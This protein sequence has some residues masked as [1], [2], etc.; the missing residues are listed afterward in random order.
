MGGCFSVMHWLMSTCTPGGVCQ[1]IIVPGS[2]NLHRNLNSSSSNSYHQEWH[3]LSVLLRPH[4]CVG[5]QHSLLIRQIHVQCDNLGEV[6]CRPSDPG[7]CA[8]LVGTRGVQMCFAC[9]KS[10]TATY[11]HDS[12]F[13]N[14]MYCFVQEWNPVIVLSLKLPS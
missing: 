8:V 5:R 13:Y 7:F 10:I 9:M 1:W 11:V 4:L 12:T 14:G 2:E 6:Q 3:S